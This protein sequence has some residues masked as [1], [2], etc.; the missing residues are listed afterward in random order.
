MQFTKDIKL[1][2]I[3]TQ[4]FSVKSFFI[5]KASLELHKKMSYEKRE[6]VSKRDPKTGPSQGL[7]I[8]EGT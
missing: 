6:N 3:L 1:S 8:R 2:F 7:K 5:P 4:F